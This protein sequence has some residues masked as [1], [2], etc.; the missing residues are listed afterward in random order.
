MQFLQ[1]I[2]INYL[3]RYVIINYLY[4]TKY[5]QF[6]IIYTAI[7]IIF[8]IIKMNVLI[9]RFREYSLEEV[10]ISILPKYIFIYV[11]IINIEC[12]MYFKTTYFSTILKI[13]LYYF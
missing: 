11:K 5:F 6:C 1:F 4:L 12:L 3:K 10:Y 8:V 2:D 13:N 7:Y 9:N